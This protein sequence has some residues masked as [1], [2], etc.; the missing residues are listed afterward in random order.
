MEELSVQLASSDWVCPVQLGAVHAAVL[1]AQWGAVQAQA[2]T[3]DC[4]MCR[5]CMCVLS[6]RSSHAPVWQSLFALG[7]FCTDATSCSAVHTEH[8]P[9]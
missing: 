9:S 5:Q 8:S 4:S 7:F 2:C 1:Q 3:V 6:S